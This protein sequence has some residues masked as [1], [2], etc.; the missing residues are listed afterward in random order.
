[1]IELGLTDD[2][3][4]I[5]SLSDTISPFQ[6]HSSVHDVQ[7]SLI[8]EFDV[9]YLIGR[10]TIHLYLENDLPPW[11]SSPRYLEAHL[12][13]L[14]IFVCH[15][16]LWDTLRDL[17]NKLPRPKCRDWKKFNHL[18]VIIYKIFTILEQSVMQQRRWMDL[19]LR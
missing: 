1:M 4:P 3:N 5:F 19:L 11:L 12:I 7:R 13:F 15:L 8:L 18:L 10:L 6:N 14:S 9:V 17:P 16:F 2:A